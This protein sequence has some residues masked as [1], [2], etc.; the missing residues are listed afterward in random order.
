M[1][2]FFTRLLAFFG[3]AGALVGAIITPFFLR[4]FNIGTSVWWT[5]GFIALGICSV[6]TCLLA[7]LRGIKEDEPHVDSPSK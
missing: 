7:M 5:V 2:N 6:L 1:K 3:L 4:A